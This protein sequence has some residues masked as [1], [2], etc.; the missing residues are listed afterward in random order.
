MT[1]AKKQKVGTQN[2]MSAGENMQTYHYYGGVVSEYE[3]GGRVVVLHPGQ[4]VELQADDGRV[5]SL[6]AQGLL[7]HYIK[8]DKKVISVLESEEN[9]EV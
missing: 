6:V 9:K 4:E 2:L 3:I 5:K 1:V 7:V 8:K